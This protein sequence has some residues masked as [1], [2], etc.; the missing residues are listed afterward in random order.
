MNHSF[1]PEAAWEFAEAVR[2]YQQRG[3]NL[4]SRF[5]REIRSTIARI[6]ATPE[7]WQFLEADVRR[8]LV[9]VFPYRVLYSMEVDC[10]L[11]IAVMHEKREPGYWRHR[12]ENRTR[13]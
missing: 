1:H 10:L 7:R 8:C 3:P 11:I 4:G 2:Y 13:R 9:R 5:D 6:T 12:L